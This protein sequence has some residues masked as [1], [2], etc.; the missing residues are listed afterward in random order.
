M[1]LTDVNEKYVERMQHKIPEIGTIERNGIIDNSDMRQ[2]IIWDLDHG[3]QRRLSLV[4]YGGLHILASLGHAAP[5]NLS[6]PLGL[7]LKI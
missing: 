2:Y 5:L 1:K 4:F 3:G 6:H 7:D